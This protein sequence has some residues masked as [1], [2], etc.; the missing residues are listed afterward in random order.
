MRAVVQDR[1][2]I[3]ELRLEE[4]DEPALADDGV[5]V[6]VRA[7]SVNRAQCYMV[8]GVPYLGRPQTGLRRPRTRVVPGV[9][10]AGTVEAVGRDV[11]HVRPGDEVFGGRN[12]AY[13]EYVCVREAVVPKPPNLSFEEAAAVPT[14]AITALQGLRDRAGLQPGQRVL[15]NGAS[16]GVGTFAVQ[17]AKA[18]GAEVTAV[19]STRNVGQARELGADHVIDYQKEDFTQ[20]RD[21]HDVLFD[22]AGSKPWHAVKNVLTPDGILIQAGAPSG[23]RLLGPLRHIALTRLASLGSRR[24]ATFFLAKFNRP[25]METLRRLIEDGK[26]RPVVERTYP[27]DEVSDALRHV[28]AGH[29]RAKVVIRI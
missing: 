20:R 27:L 19:C 11:D 2:G 26:V 13:A 3:D 18:L 10:F 28:A 9:D 16:G 15:V 8:S 24:T 1:Y 5:L 12:G 14:A 7:S 17:I 25:D 23:G 22:V 6:R 29:A 4:V 21:R